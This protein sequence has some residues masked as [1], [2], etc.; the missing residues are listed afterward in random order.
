MSSSQSYVSRRGELETY[1]DRTASDAWAKLTSD[2][3]VS[4]IRATV[5][6]GRDAIRQQVLDWLPKD[7]SGARLLDAGCGP[8]QFS[9]EAARRGADILAVDLSPTLLGLAQQ[10][11]E[12]M[13]L[14][15]RVR[16]LAG[17][18]LDPHHGDF[19]YV[20]A[21]DSL[22][23]YRAGD[24]VK[25]LSQF[26]DRTSTGIICTIAPKTALLA[27]MHAVGQFF[28]K[29]DKAPAIQ[30][31]APKRLYRGMAT[32]PILSKW[33]VRQTRRV[34]STFYISEAMEIRPA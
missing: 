10:R 8:G 31:L 2:A 1:F 28:P 32:D 11:A 4:K 7:L 9:L 26:A 25:S 23:H 13:G 5:R 22:I 3:P 34:A 15:Q 18:M 30:P 20:V 6:A 27:T 29:A 33:E 21:M 16:F 12:A 14:G 19:D 17:D 24:V